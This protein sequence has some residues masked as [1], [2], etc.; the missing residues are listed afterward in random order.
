M[1]TFEVL[2][3]DKSSLLSGEHSYH[4]NGLGSE[5]SY[6]KFQ[7]FSLKHFVV[8]QVQLLNSFLLA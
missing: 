5:H 3:A 8:L 7:V 6:K 4:L 2:L 1:T